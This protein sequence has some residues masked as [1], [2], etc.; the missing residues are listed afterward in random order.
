MASFGPLSGHLPPRLLALIE[1][2]GWNESG[3][4]VCGLALALAQ[5]GE[6]P[7]PP[8]GFVIDVYASPPRCLLGYLGGK[9][10]SSC[11]ST[12]G[13]GQPSVLGVMSLGRVDGRCGVTQLLGGNVCWR[14]HRSGWCWKT[15]DVHQ[16]AAWRRPSGLPRWPELIAVSLHG[17][18]GGS[19][20]GGSGVALVVGFVLVMLLARS[21]MVAGMLLGSPFGQLRNLCG[22]AACGGRCRIAM[23]QPPPAMFP[24]G[25]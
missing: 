1:G 2:I 23:I 5:R 12:L 7:R 3:P 18:G 20:G 11:W 10:A 9:P 22:L 17:P 21:L 16:P 14:V 24:R 8:S 4:C 15:P 6:R 19:P 25:A 13:A